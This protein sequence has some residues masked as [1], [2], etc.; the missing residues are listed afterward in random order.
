MSR[1]GWVW[2]LN[3]RQIDGKI[4]LYSCFID[5]GFKTFETIDRDELQSVAKYLRLNVVFT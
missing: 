5:Y 2:Y 4:N 3:N 1:A